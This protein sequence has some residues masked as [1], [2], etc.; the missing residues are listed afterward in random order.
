VQDV[1]R[2]SLFLAEPQFA[3]FQQLARES[4]R[5]YSELIRE[6]LDGY[7]RGHPRADALKQKAERPRAGTR[8]RS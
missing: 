3:A 8:K 5:P 7:L 6:A 4:G 1:K 2:I